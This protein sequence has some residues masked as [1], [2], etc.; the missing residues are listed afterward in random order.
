MLAERAQRGVG[1]RFYSAP[2][3]KKL[4]AR[5]S[6]EKALF[7]AF[8]EGQFQLQYQP[9]VSLSDGVCEG[10][11]T[12]LRWNH[13]QK[14]LLPAEEFIDHLNETGLIQPVGNWVILQAC[15]DWKRWSEAS[16][17]RT[18]P[19]VSVN[20][21]ASQLRGKSL[22]KSIRDGVTQ[23][24]IP[25]G[26]LKV[27]VPEEV[28]KGAEFHDVLEELH[29]MGV[30]LMVDGF[31]RGDCAIG[32]LNRWPVEGVKLDYRALQSLESSERQRLVKTLVAAAHAQDIDV[33]L[34]GVEQAAEGSVMDEF[35]IDCMQG[36]CL[37][38]PVA[39]RQFQGG[40]FVV[41]GF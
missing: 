4:E 8:R 14:G 10:Y 29:C 21:S 26:A 38:Y 39:S 5:Q 37:G 15:A 12:L 36:Y 2:L 7:V 22:C 3:Q 11:E 19:Y 40:R 28:L 17:T 27:E 32:Y 24:G 9:I 33:T 20:I 13:P 23:N 18:T 41:T 35:G 1:Y 25:R 34:V 31:G 30:A 6:L 16:T